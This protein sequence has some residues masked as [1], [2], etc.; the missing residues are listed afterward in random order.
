MKRLIPLLFLCGCTHEL[1]PEEVAAGVELC[2][3]LHLKPVA[4]EYYETPGMVRKIGCM[5]YP[6]KEHD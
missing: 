4:V 6:E 3:K 2:H 5:P 1:T